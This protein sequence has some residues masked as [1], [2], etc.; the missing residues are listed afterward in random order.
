MRTD[1]T[2]NQAGPE[3]RPPLLPLKN[4]G[5]QALVD[6]FIADGWI[7]PEHRDR[8]VIALYQGQIAAE[9]RQSAETL[10]KYV[11]AMD[12]LA[13]EEYAAGWVGR[14]LEYAEA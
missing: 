4:C 13:A 12:R 9:R 2:K 1:R 7:A 5:N 3:N 8:E 6:G 14:I 11:S 10:R